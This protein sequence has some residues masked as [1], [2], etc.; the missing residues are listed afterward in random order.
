MRVV[1][2][3]IVDKVGRQEPNGHGKLIQRHH[4]PAVTGDGYL[5]NINRCNDGNHTDA[6]AAHNAVYHKF[7]ERH[8]YCTAY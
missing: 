8:G 3:Q 4:L 1:E 2:Q 6:D 5:T 7:G